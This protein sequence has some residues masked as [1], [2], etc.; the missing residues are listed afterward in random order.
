MSC[1]ISFDSIVNTADYILEYGSYI[2]DIKNYTGGFMS[3]EGVTLYLPFGKSTIKYKDQDIHITYEKEDKP[4]GTQSFAL[5]YKTVDIEADNKDIIL[6]FLDE[7]KEFCIGKKEKNEVICYMMINGLWRSVSKLPK[8]PMDTIYISQ[9]IKDN[10]VQ[11]IENYLEN[12]DFYNNLGIPYKRNYIFY[13][14]PGTGKTSS[15]FAIASKFDMNIGFSNFTKQLNDASFVSGLSNIPNNTILVLE[16]IDRLFVNNELDKTSI[17]F[18][19][20]LNSLDGISRKHKLITIMTANNIKNIQQ[21][22]IRP[23]RIDYKQYFGYMSFEQIQMML[24]KFL[25][26]KKEIH[27]EFIEKIKK[28]RIRNIT[29][30]CIQQYLLCNMKKDNLIDDIIELKTL[31]EEQDGANNNNMYL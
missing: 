8:R 25:P 24:D 23:G 28:L 4:V 26:D 31:I 6:E 27:E 15:I 11:D 9:E 22:V 1:K 19:G 14:P 16:D 18:S 29:P 20:L 2:S 5:Y 7:A 30:A 17:T 12:E 13:G 10:I 3:K 21:V